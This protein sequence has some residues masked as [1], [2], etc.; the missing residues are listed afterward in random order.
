MRLNLI[1]LF[2]WKW[3]VQLDNLDI[4]KINNNKVL[5]NCDKFTKKEISFNSLD[6]LQYIQSDQQNLEINLVL[7]DNSKLKFNLELED[8]AGEFNIIINVEIYDNAQLE[9]L[10]FL[11][12]KNIK[13][14]FICNL[15]GLNSE[16]DM[17]ALIFVGFNSFNVIN[18][19]QNHLSANT[20][21]SVQT[22]RILSHDSISK[23]YGK[24]L[25]SEYANNSDASQQ[26]AVF[27]LGDNIKNSSVPALEIKNN[28]VKCKHAFFAY[29]PDEQSVMYLQTRGFEDSQISRL[30]IDSFINSL[31]NDNTFSVFFNKKNIL[32]KINKLVD[33]F[34]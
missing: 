3:R 17:R 6:I 7:Q 32:S 27:V 10:F 15:V 21:S 9:S 18:T 4:K 8:L 22:R 25:I 12:S 19:F 11:S 31:F 2:H 33:N 14:D 23:Y 5:I 24:I 29:K 28:D 16:C 34:F 20:K 13:I 26:D 30:F 1:A